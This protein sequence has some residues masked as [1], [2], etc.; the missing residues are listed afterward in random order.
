MSELVQDLPADPQF[1]ERVEAHIGFAN[2]KAGQVPSPLV[3][4]SLT[5]AAARFNAWLLTNSS[6]SP[7]DMKA[8]RDSAIAHLVDHYR[9]HLEQNYDD[10]QANYATYMPAGVQTRPKL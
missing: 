9:K 2:Q 10:F 1:L 5:Y 7:E 3:A 6:V 4:G 8:R